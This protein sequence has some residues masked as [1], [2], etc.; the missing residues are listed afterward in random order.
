MAQKNT[1]KMLKSKLPQKIKFVID[2]PIYGSNILVIFLYG[3][4][5]KERIED[6]E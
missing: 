6:I 4:S 3:Q 5:L 2:F 1:M